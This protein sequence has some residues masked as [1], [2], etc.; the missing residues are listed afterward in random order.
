MS[1]VKAT[2]KAGTDAVKNLISGWEYM[3]KNEVVVGITEESSVASSDGISTAALLYI[4]ENGS[5]VNNIPPRPVLKPALAQEEVHSEIVDLMKQATRKALVGDK[6]GAE[7]CWKKAGMFA[8]TACKNYI[9]SGS[10]APN[11]P[12]TIHGG[13][14]RNKVSG[15]F[16]HVKGKGSSK[17]LIDTGAM[18]NSITYEIRKKKK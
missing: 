12:I 1:F 9:V 11:A 18:M 2:V 4:H 7:N 15:K 13:W 5:P 10:F 16:F 6:N 14:M 3:R 17:P 8:Q